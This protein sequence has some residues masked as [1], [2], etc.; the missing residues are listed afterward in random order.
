MKKKI[1]LIVAIVFGIAL[2]FFG[3]KKFYL[4]K[5]NK[6]KVV[7]NVDET[8]Q[9]NIDSTAIETVAASDTLQIGD[10]DD[11]SSNSENKDQQEEL[12]KWLKKTKYYIKKKNY[13]KAKSCF[14]QLKVFTKDKKMLEDL[15]SQVDNIK[16]SKSFSKKENTTQNWI[17]ERVAAQD[18]T[19][20][21]IKNSATGLKLSNRYYSKEVAEKE[22]ENF[23]N[24]IK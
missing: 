20:Y 12:N 13:S 6:A 23:K 21:V 17:I 14:K 3:F 19:Y 18:T 22:L 5:Q 9:P 10:E 15:K 1:V 16:N 2:C 8:S 7:E 4:E 24:I 11:K